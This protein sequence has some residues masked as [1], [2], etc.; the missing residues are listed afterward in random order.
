MIADY[1]TGVEFNCKTDTQCAT[2]C[3]TGNYEWRI[4]P[5]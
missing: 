5:L 3:Y 4:C 2:S 1:Y